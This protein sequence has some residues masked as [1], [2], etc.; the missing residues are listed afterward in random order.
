M[1]NSLSKKVHSI[2]I[3]KLLDLVKRSAS[4]RGIAIGKIADVPE[5]RMVTESMG[6]TNVDLVLDLGANRGQ[7]AKGIRSAGYTNEIFSFEPAPDVFKL[8]EAVKS[9]DMKWKIFNL[10]II[11]T[12]EKSI[13]LNVTSNMGYSSSILNFS[14]LGNEIYPEIDVLYS[15]DVPCKTLIKVL[16]EVSTEARIYIKADIQG[17]E[18][19]LFRKFDLRADRRIKGVMIEISLIE[20]YDGEWGISEAISYFENNGFTLVGVTPEDHDENFG[21]PQ[22]NLYF[23]KRSN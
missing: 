20:I 11:D 9:G 4:R 10:A 17:F 14:P 6:R 13:Q 2:Y 8:L 5:Y 21:H 18:A 22:V 1:S 23:E 12:D 16:E 7:F 19:K 15:I 3:P